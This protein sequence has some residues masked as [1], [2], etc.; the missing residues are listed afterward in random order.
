[1]ASGEDERSDTPRV[2]VHSVMD[3]RAIVVLLAGLLDRSAADD[4]C[5][6]ADGK[7]QLQCRRGWQTSYTS[8][9]RRC[10]RCSRP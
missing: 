3:Y 7:A 6:T 10:A 1:M 5:S 8:P 4:L 9:D 2:R